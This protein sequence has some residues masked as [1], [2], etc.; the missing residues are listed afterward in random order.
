MTLRIPQDAALRAGLLSPLQ[1]RVRV[2][3]PGQ[4]SD[5][6][7]IYW[8]RNA[9]R[10]HENPALDVAVSISNAMHV[11]LLVLLHIDD[12]YPHATAR[13]QMFL[14][15]GARAT[16]A[17]LTL[18]GVHVHVQVDISKNR[19]SVYSMLGQ[20]SV[21]V[22]E[23]A[24]CVPWLAGI[25]L[26]VRMTTQVPIWLVDSSGVV[27]NSL[28][29]RNSCHRAYAFEKATQQL[30]ANNVALP[31]HDV[32]LDSA[33]DPAPF[34]HDLPPSLDL[35]SANLTALVQEMDVDM[36]IQPVQHTTGG[37]AAGYARWEA[38]ICG[39]G[40]KTYAQ[41]RNDSLDPLGVSRMSAYLNTGMVS[42]MR[43]AREATASSGAGK[44][45]YLNEFLTWRGLSY[46]HFYHFPMPAS[47]VQLAQLPP[48]AQET[49]HKHAS[50]SRRVIGR[51]TL[52]A[53]RSGDL[54]WDGM[55]RYLVETGE[56]HNNARMGWGKA[57]AKWTSSPE[58]ALE[59]LVELNNRYALDGHAP[60]SYAGLLG[61]LGLFEGPKAEGSIY[62]KV[63]F[64]PPKSKYSG[65]QN[66]TGL[67]ALPV[68]GTPT[69]RPEQSFY[70]ATT[71]HRQVLQGTATHRPDTEKPLVES[72]SRK[73]R[74]AP[75]CQ[76]STECIDLT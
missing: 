18:R 50:D 57:I 16:Q 66:N 11:P 45:K 75:K 68:K 1:H 14:L 32:A 23:E 21:I 36:S 54:G 42:P 5:R 4:T 2:A 31:W 6:P 74:W 35:V 41:R 28:V 25:E 60:P 67:L 61:C 76:S 30:H 10:G 53:G 38:W 58:Q 55:Q 13:R 51:A 49:L 3:R 52:A 71:E 46:A 8:M 20:A 39:G 40:L 12:Q 72:N 7:V 44:A 62:G 63:S 24:F 70:S 56:L 37:S 19:T 15:E 43:L 64:K 59:V 17:E 29:P 69:H 47:G 65:M 33:V 48:W 73:R 27:P 22:A 9:L 34:L 26:L